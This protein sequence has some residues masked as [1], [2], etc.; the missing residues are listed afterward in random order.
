V[1]A[2]EASCSGSPPRA[3]RL[4][5]VRALAA[6][7]SGS[8]PQARH[9]CVCARQRAM[10]LWDPVRAPRVTH[11]YSGGLVSGRLGCT[12]C[13]L[14]LMAPFVHPLVWCY[15]ADAAHTLRWRRLAIVA[16]CVHPSVWC[17]PA[18]FGMVLPCR[19]CSRSA[20]APACHSGPMCAL[21]GMVLACRC[22]SHTAVAPAPCVHSLVWYYPA[23]AHA[24]QW[25][26][27]HVCTLWYGATLPSLTHCS[28]A[29][30]MC[31]LSG[32]VLPCR[33]CSRTAV[34]PACHGGPMCALSGATLP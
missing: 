14:A 25:R 32:M 29:G 3:L 24:L 21:S 13:R 10:A 16:P 11:R 23:V 30:P 12:A 15:P 6:S 7:G 19:C 31:A 2:L 33:C 5:L 8:S 9:S 17:Y 28:G 22:C 27:P 34:A 26:R 1:S 4:R 18:P 20:V